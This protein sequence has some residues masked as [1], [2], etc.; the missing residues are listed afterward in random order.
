MDA[1]YPISTEQIEK[2]DPLAPNYVGTYSQPPPYQMHQR[3]PVTAKRH[4]G[5]KAGYR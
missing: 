5:T 3:P 1:S 2:P 4:I